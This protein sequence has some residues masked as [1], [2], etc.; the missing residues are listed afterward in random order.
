MRLSLEL[1]KLGLWEERKLGCVC[2]MGGC[3]WYILRDK[4]LTPD[5]QAV[6]SI[7]LVIGL[8]LIW[9]VGSCLC[10]WAKP[11]CLSGGRCLCLNLIINLPYCEK[12]V[13]LELLFF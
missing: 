9:G 1:P 7:L 4:G 6:V 3:L 2:V 5:H 12:W 8:Y 11:S 10:V 13:R